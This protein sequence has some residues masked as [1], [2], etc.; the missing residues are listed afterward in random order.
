MEPACTL[1]IADTVKDV[2]SV[3]SGL[4]DSSDRVRGVKLI[5]SKT[6]EL[7]RE[8]IRPGQSNIVKTFSLIHTH[9]GDHVSE[10]FIQP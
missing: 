5:S 8:E 6:P 4:A 7:L 10:R 2:F 1:T 3:G 9:E